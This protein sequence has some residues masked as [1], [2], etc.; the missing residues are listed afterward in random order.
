MTNGEIGQ[1]QPPPQQPQGPKDNSM[2]MVLSYLW[3]LALV[4]LLVEKDDKEVQWHAKHGLVLT[5][6]EIIL[7]IGIGIVSVVLGQ[8]SGCLGS[9]GC[10]W[11]SIIWLGVLV[12]RILC[13]MK[14]TK[15]ERFIIP[16]ISDF[17]NKF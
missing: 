14:A 2:M 5:A 17:A 1:P 8:I 6:A 15:G 3:L 11:T 9:I 7:S 13:I 16:Q 4:P 12:V 10:F